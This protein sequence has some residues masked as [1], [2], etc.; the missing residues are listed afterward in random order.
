[1]DKYEVLPEIITDMLIKQDQ[2]IEAIYHIGK[3]TYRTK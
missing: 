1:M 3:K 2:T